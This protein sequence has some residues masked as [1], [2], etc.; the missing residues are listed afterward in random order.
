ME[1][2]KALTGTYTRVAGSTTKGVLIYQEIFEKVAI[3]SCT[4]VFSEF[5][6]G[7][8]KLLGCLAKFLF[9]SI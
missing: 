6:V 4:G 2:N 8:G 3:D 1:F 5:K 9:S 7:V